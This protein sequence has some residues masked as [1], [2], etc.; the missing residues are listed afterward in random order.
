MR[1]L[2]VQKTVLHIYKIYANKNVND[3]FHS[4]ICLAIV[5]KIIKVEMQICL[6]KHSNKVVSKR[7]EEENVLRVGCSDR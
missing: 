6:P 2:H 4:K 1:D 5:Y 7:R 3:I